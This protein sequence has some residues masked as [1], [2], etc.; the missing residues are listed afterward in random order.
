MDCYRVYAKIVLNTLAYLYGKEY[1]LSPSFNAIK[2][3]V[4]KGNNIQ[5]YVYM[6]EGE[7]PIKP[8]I[9]KFPESFQFGDQFHSVVFVK[10]DGRVYGFISLY[11]ADNPVIVELGTIDL[12]F[13]IDAYIC[14]WENQKD[15]KL[16]DCVLKICGYDDDSFSMNE[17]YL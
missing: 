13:N 2:E 10:R 17:G 6:V 12:P 9:S 3:A 5:K 14:D 7:N 11:G 4:L 15:Y 8:T 16:I 1:I